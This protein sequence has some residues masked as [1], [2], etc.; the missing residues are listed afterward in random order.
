MT[1]SEANHET[2][3]NILLHFQYPKLKI[4]RWL[5]VVLKSFLNLICIFRIV[6]RGFY[7]D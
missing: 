7:V 3:L 6:L 2:I 4:V 5:E 1:I